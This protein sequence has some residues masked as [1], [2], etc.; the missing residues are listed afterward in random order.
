MDNSGVFRVHRM[1]CLDSLEGRLRSPHVDQAPGDFKRR[2]EANVDQLR[3]GR[4]HLALETGRLFVA[5][6]GEAL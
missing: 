2:E 5:A 6:A 3:E 4:S 1:P